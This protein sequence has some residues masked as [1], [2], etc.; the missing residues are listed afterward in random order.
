MSILAAIGGGSKDLDIV[1]SGRDLAEAFGED[2]VVLHVMEEEEFRSRRERNPDFYQDVA[3][4]EA[5]SFARARAEDATEIEDLRKTSEIVADGTVG[6][7][8]K[9]I[10]EKA[11]EH[12]ARYLVIGGRK[13]TPVGKVIFGSVTQSVLLDADRPVVTITGD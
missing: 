12:D 11:I 3:A 8:T 1:I 13:R 9:M 2:L 7:P 10:Q 6:E 4:D 5:E